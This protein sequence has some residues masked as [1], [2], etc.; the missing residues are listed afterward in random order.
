MTT[1]TFPDTT[2]AAPTGMNW[3]P[4]FVG[5]VSPGAHGPLAAPTG[6]L[7]ASASTA[8]PSQQQQQQQQQKKEPTTLGTIFLQ[9]QIDQAIAQLD[10]RDRRAYQTA[11]DV[12]PHLVK[13]ETPVASFWRT[14]N[15][16]VTAAATRLAKYWKF[17]KQILPSDGCC[18]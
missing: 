8:P 15:G 16:N 10:R 9:D 14:E 4:A 12:V 6:P 5:Q 3:T 13:A 7:A 2:T 1:P 18:P 17:R 11:V